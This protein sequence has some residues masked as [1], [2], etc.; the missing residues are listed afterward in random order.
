MKFEYFEPLNEKNSDICLKKKELKPL[1]S[2]DDSVSEANADDRDQDLFR[3]YWKMLDDDYIQFEL[4]ARTTGW[5]GFG[6]SPNGGMNGA[7]MVIGWVDNNGKGHFKV[8]K[9]I[10]YLIYFF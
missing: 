9:F 6:I 8:I 4:H 10:Y 5:V 7:D 2:S 1:V 3:V